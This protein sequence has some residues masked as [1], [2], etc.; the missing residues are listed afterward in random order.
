MRMK[1]SICLVILICLLFTA[2][3]FAEERN[4]L[5]NDVILSMTADDYATCYRILLNCKKSQVNLSNDELDEIATEFYIATYKGRQGSL[6]VTSW[7]DNLLM[8]ETGINSDEL[9]LAK[10]YPSDLA[11]VYTASSIAN[12]ET[13]S[14]YNK[15]LY[16][17]NADAFRH[18]AWSALLV[19]RFYALGKGNFAWCSSRANEWTTAHETGATVD[20]S[21]SSSQRA[22]DHEMDILNNAAGRA[23]A[24]TTYTSESLALSKVQNYVDNGF[25]KRIMTNAQMNANYGY[26]DMKNVSSWTLKATNTVGKC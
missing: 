18:A 5:T 24:E 8:N 9:A 21:L 14:R 20:S 23:A 12:T 6:Q 15:G 13:T 22:A 2:Q 16:L 26:A 19:C 10:M 17:G 11:A 3:A 1:F 25:C 4:E 7:Y